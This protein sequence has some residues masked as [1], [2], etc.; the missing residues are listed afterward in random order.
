MHFIPSFQVLLLVFLLLVVR[1]ETGFSQASSTAISDGNTQTDSLISLVRNQKE[2]DTRQARATLDTLRKSNGVNSPVYQAYLLLL[3]GEILL[4]ENQEIE[5][6]VKVEEALSLFENLDHSLGEIDVYDALSN[7]NSRAA[8]Y[9]EALT[10]AFKSIV[11]KEKTNDIFGLAQSFTDIA[12]IYWYYGRFPESIDYGK[13]A[14]ALIENQGPSDE[15]A[16]AYKMLS[17]SYLEIPDYDLALVY[18]SQSIAIKKSLGAGPLELASAINSRGNIYKFLKRYDE[19]IDDYASNLR[20]CDSVG[21][22]IGSRASA[23]NLGHVHLLKREYAQAIPYKLR[24][25]DIQESSGQTQQMA[26]NLMHLSDAYA[27]IGDQEEALKYR[28]RYDSIKS[29]EHE[30]A[31]DKLS[32]ELSVKYET[33]KKEESIRNLSDRVQLQNISMILGA[34]LLLISL[35]AIAIFLRLNTELKIRNRE[36]EILLKEIHHRTKNNLQILSSLLSL[37]SDHLVDASAI[38]AITEGKNRVESMGL[39]HQRLYTGEGVTVV[40]LKDYIHELCRHLEK[41]Y[42]TPD[43]KIWISE[44]ICY[45]KMDVDYAIPLGLIINELVTNSVKYAYDI[46]E[47][48]EVLLKLWREN[49]ELILQV[50]D[51]GNKEVGPNKSNISTSFG[52]ML[53]ATLSKKLKGTIDISQKDGYSTIIRFQRFEN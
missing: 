50:S 39:I 35:V 37:Q 9:P 40:D 7:Y 31:L 48:G 26:E 32:N 41:S 49:Q 10:Y 13:K 30:Q 20:I 24:S 53:V 5:G 27:G 19:A 14:V 18:I 8:R 29:I 21:Y 23:A 43:R 15:L 11:L 12:D 42:S 2:I 3:E 16:S 44:D 33:E 22:K 25:L 38:D 47:S 1:R 45:D 17:E 6:L 46:T 52:S 28:I 34:T 51:H 36:K 4:E